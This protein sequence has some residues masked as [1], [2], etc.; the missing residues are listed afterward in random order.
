MRSQHHFYLAL[1]R[2]QSI[3]DSCVIPLHNVVGH[4]VEVE[5]L[6]PTS[7]EGTWNWDKQQQELHVHLPQRYSARLFRI[8]GFS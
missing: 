6:Y 3:E 5:C 8:L 4:S 2:Q 1:W 7:T